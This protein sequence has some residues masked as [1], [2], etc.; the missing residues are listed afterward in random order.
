MSGYQTSQERKRTITI[1]NIDTD[2]M[3]PL[4]VGVIANVSPTGL[5]STRLLGDNLVLHVRRPRL[6]DM[7]EMNPTLWVVNVGPTIPRYNKQNPSLGIGCMEWP[8]TAL[9]LYVPGASTQLGKS[10]LGQPYGLIENQWFLR[11]SSYG[12]SFLGFDLAVPADKFPGTDSLLGGLVLGGYTPPATD[13]Q[14]V[15]C[16]TPQEIAA[17]GYATL[18]DVMATV[19]GWSD[20]SWSTGVAGTVNDDKKLY[21]RTPG[22]YMVHFHGSVEATGITSDD[23]NVILSVAVQKGELRG[24]VVDEDVELLPDVYTNGVMQLSGSR[25][26]LVDSD[27]GYDGYWL[28]NPNVTPK[29]T[30]ENIAFSGPVIYQPT[31]TASG[32]LSPTYGRE[33]WLRVVNTSTRPIKLY[34]AY[35]TITL[36]QRLRILPENA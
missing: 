30:R 28:D 7:I 35:L 1:E 6:S 34:G 36:M 19:I 13:L 2:A 25:K 23:D 27:T 20:E 16:D 33:N 9:G 31:L 3:P 22:L 4:G 32:D 18:K 11:P 29:V 26:A 15:L 24:G 14:T 12:L 5:S 17:G 21:L 8:Q 10:F